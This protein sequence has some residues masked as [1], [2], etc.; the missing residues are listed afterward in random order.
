MNNPLQYYVLLCYVITSLKAANCSSVV[1]NIF[2][3]FYFVVLQATQFLTPDF[4][5]FVPLS[6][7]N[8]YSFFSTLS[9]CF[10]I[11]ASC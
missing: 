1:H 5:L 9:N 10:D 8:L 11:I 2:L 6:I 4:I 3:L 7:N